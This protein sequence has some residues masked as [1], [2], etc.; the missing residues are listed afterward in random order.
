MDEIGLS[1]CGLF[2]LN[3]SKSYKMKKIYPYRTS[4]PRTDV[5]T[6]ILR[7]EVATMIARNLFG[8]KCDNHI[9]GI[10]DDDMLVHY[11]DNTLRL[12]CSALIAGDTNKEF[13]TL[14]KIIE[15]KKK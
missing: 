5:H 11:S 15:R 4:F 8:E 13:M 1:C 7:G 9:G 3:N 12:D 6:Q 14:Q 2:A 10:T